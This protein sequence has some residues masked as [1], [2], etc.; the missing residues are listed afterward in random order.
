MIPSL[1]IS[2]APPEHPALDWAGLV[3][4]GRATLAAMSEGGWTDF[5]AH[6]PGITI[7]EVIAYAL[8]DL[9]YRAHH[10]ITDLMA[11]AEAPLGPAAALTSRA[12]TLGDLRRLGSDV[13][14]ARNV[15]IEPGASA[16]L[17]LRHAAGAAELAL[18]G[19]Q[20]E[21]TLVALA[22]VHR[23]VVEKVP[24]EDRS[25]AELARAVALRLHAERNL[26]EDFESFAVL[27]AYPIVVFAEVEIADRARAEDILI[28]ILRRLEGHFS[29]QVERRTVAAMRAAGLASDAIYEGPLVTQG[30]T[31]GP[32]DPAGRRRTVRLSD[33]M[34]VLASTPGVRATRKVRIGGTPGEAEKGPLAWSLTLPPDRV[35]AFDLQSSRIRLLSGQVDAIEPGRE[36]SL[37][38]SFVAAMRAETPPSDAMRDAPPPRGR[39]R[40]V[41]DYRPLRFDLPRAYAVT[42]GGLARDASDARRGAANQ[43]RAYLGIVDALLANSFA[44][45]GGAAQLLADG[46]GDGRSYFAQAAERPLDDE[47]PVVSSALTAKSL[48]ALVEEPGGEAATARRN[49]FLEHLLARLG[50]TVPA[51]PQPVA[52]GFGGDKTSAEMLRLRARRG[53]LK[54][55]ERLSSGRGSGANLLAEG[56]ESPLLERI[57]LK[58]AL[59]PPAADRVLLV[60]HILLRGHADDTSAALPLLSAVA[61]ADPYSLQLSFVIDRRL[62]AAGDDARSIERVIR[63]ECPAHLIAYVHW[64]GMKEFNIF[65]EAHGRWLEALRRHR[66]ESLEVPGA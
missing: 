37:V 54:G 56:D 6:D 33:V 62:G 27:E 25:A 39:D 20:A 55:F 48:Q 26:G 38:A 28:E 9:G 52:V 36:A 5:N 61:R 23:V 21:G 7:L 60:E 50:E 29:P 14:G 57:R 58:L 1:S 41:S 16:G 24:R 63:D 19:E 22:G 17:K 34:S 53:F 44:Q 2:A 35:P 65:A 46:P 64:L 45:L 40:R 43:L 47:A 42:P 49:R 11:G 12:A 30:I 10:P 66:R 18:D 51:V 3:E 59:P 13:A 15:W 4:E 8:T 31:A 32:A